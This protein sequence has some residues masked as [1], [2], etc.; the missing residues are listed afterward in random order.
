VDSIFSILQIIK[1]QKKK[2]AR[3]I[4]MF[5]IL[6]EMKVAYDKRL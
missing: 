3:I 1:K 2:L 6:E 5:N 4:N